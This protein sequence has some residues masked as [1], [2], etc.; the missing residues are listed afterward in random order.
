MDA[1]ID[2]KISFHN[3]RHS[4]ATLVLTMGNDIYTL[5]KLL[6]HNNVKTTQ[7]YAKVIDQRK[8]DAVNSMNILNLKS[9]D[10]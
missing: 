1:G 4:F 9:E 2:K 5:S 7:I 6:G 8:V 10:T 3:A